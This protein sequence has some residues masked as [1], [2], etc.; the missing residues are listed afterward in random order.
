MLIDEMIVKAIATRVCP[1]CDAQ[2]GEPCVY[3]DVVMKTIV[4]EQPGH[5][6]HMARIKK[7][8]ADLAGDGIDFPVR[9]D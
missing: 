3:R 1:V 4:A 2:P 9:G 5:Q 7:D 6:C 8:P